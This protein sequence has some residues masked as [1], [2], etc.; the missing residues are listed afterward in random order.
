MI[1][2]AHDGSIYGD[3]VARYAIHFAAQEQDHKL[4]LLHVVD[5]KVGPEI[6]DSRFSSLAAECDACNVEFLPQ[7][8]L[9][10]PSVHRTLRQAI[11][12][13]PEALLVC[14]TRVKPRR[15]NYLA[16]T[17]SE[18]LLRMHQ[19][20]VVALRVVQPGL[21]GNPH[22]LLLP[23]AGHLHGYFRVAPILLRLGPSLR[24]LHMCRA[25]RINPLRHPQLSRERELLLKEIGRKYLAKFQTEM[26]EA[27]GPLPFRC[28]QQTV[29][30]SDWVLEI[31]LQASRL[32]SQLML[33]G[34]SER[35]L[36]YRVFH[37]TEIER[38]IHETPCDIGIYR[39]L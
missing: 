13:D 17:V 7:H 37:S 16:G 33:L 36:A 6:V 27:L 32:R 28:E 26:E 9:L 35:S 20:P 12:P 22:E 1:I 34:L 5:G 21:L 25:M 30:A 38:I 18:K 19:C 15:Q 31:L 4:L 11:P 23:L 39:G 8:L 24:S 3:W 29:I 10:G 2:L 14:G